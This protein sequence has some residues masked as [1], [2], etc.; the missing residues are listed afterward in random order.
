VKTRGERHI[1]A[2]SAQIHC[3]LSIDPIVVRGASRRAKHGTKLRTLQRVSACCICQG[4][5]TPHLAT[6]GAKGDIGEHSLW[7]PR[8][9]VSFIVVHLA[10]GQGRLDLR[11]VRRVG[12]AVT[13]VSPA[14]LWWVL[15]RVASPERLRRTYQRLDVRGVRVWEETGGEGSGATLWPIGLATHGASSR[16]TCGMRGADT[17]GFCPRPQALTTLTSTVRPE[18]QGGRDKAETRH[19]FTALNTSVR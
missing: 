4:N 8:H 9:C 11:D 18:G 7:R 5:K 6:Q 17:E 1:I 19:G 2:K 12:E 10:R 3:A 14:D 15:L 16:A 13:V